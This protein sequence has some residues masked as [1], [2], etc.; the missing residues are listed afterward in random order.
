MKKYLMTPGPTMI[1]DDVLLEMAKPII[2]HRTKEFQE[3]LK[4]T[5]EG[6]RYVF[7]TQNPVFIFASSGTGG[8]EACVCNILSSS[9]KALVIIAGKFGERWSELCKAYKIKFEVLNVPEGDC[10]DP[11]DVRK[12]L[13]KDKIKAVFS[14]LCETSSGVVSDIEA[15][16]NICKEYNSL[17]VVDAISGLCADSF[18]MDTWNVDAC[19]SGSQKGLMMPPGLCFVAVSKRVLEEAEK[20]DLCKYY[21]SFKKANKAQEK[22]DTPFTPAISLIRGLSIALDRIKKEGL[23]NVIERHKKLALATRSAVS[24]LGLSL[25]AKKPSNALTSVK[26]PEGIDAGKLYNRMKDIY[27]VNIAKGQGEL[28]DKIFRI[29]HLGYVEKF[30]LITTIAALEMTLSDLGFPVSLGLSVCEV[31]KALKEQV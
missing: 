8:M 22:N 23:S 13:Q 18:F 6:L 2:H 3:V 14:T 9:D 21:F 17:L 24:A 20:S 5:Q 25:F 28:E 15:I 12:I 11:E 29:A 7:Q 10:P 31:E 26:V 1:P 30:D 19:V 16:G 27:G 4:N